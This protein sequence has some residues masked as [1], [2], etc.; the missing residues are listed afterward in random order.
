MRFRVERALAAIGLPGLAIRMAHARAALE[1]AERAYDFAKASRATR[2]WR[3]P[4]TSAAAEVGPG[5]AVMRNRSRDLVRSNPWGIKARRQIPAHLV[6]KGVTPRPTG[7]ADR[8]RRRALDAWR[9]WSEET[10]AETGAGFAAQ[11]ALIAGTVFEAGECL[12]LWDAA[13]DSPGGWTTRVIEPD[14]LDETLNERSRN[15]GGQIVNGIEF[16]GRGRR[17]AYHLFR[18]HPGDLVPG[19][20]PRRERVRVEARFVDH[21]FEVLRPGQVRGVPFMAAAGLRLRDL[22][23]YLEAE[24]WR[25]KVTT[26]FAVFLKTPAGPAQSSLGQVRT[27]TDA[28]GGQRAIE[29]I[30]PGTIKRL[31]P[32]EEPMFVT[33]PA[34]QAL[35]GYIKAELMAVAAGIGA[36]YAEFTGDLRNANYSS[37]RVGRLEFYALLDMWQAHMLKPL[38]LRR[39]WTR[40]QAASGV[41][42]MPCEWSFPKR[43]WVDPEAEINAEIKAIRAGLLSQPDALA[44]RGDD[45]REVLAEQAAFLAEADQLQLVLDTDPRAIGASGNA[46]PATPQPAQPD[47]DGAD[48]DARASVSVQVALSDD[49]A[50]ALRAEIAPAMDGVRDAAA[51]LRDAGGQLGHA[52]ADGTAALADGARAMQDSAAQGAEAAD[53]ARRAAEAA[54]KAANRPMRAT[55]LHDERGRVT[56]AEYS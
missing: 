41:P 7:G 18:D 8:T 42:N 4:S 35:E 46:Q 9:A 23:D 37:M 55:L 32:G 10:D 12:V 50:Q 40:V 26:A 21:V 25:K 31:R 38:L 14:Y 34:D 22:D 48:S 51:A 56:G 1:E 27:E 33:P 2:G 28:A 5:L 49:M 52:L 53:A 44:A 13:P 19:L 39:A 17:V 43:P 54:A 24:R 15:G 29:R 30:S 47:G 20:F 6:G 16:D 3:T 11:Q 45:W 36:P